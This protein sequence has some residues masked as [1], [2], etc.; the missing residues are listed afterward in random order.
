MENCLTYALRIARY[1]R[2]GDHLVIRKSHWGFF[3]HFA[4]L[5]ELANGDMVRKEY[6]PI[7]PVKRWIPPLFFKG[8]EVTTYYQLVEVKNGS[9]DHQSESV[10]AGTPTGDSLP[11]CGAGDGASSAVRSGCGV[12][13]MARI[14]QRPSAFVLSKCL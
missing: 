6:V 8:R 13:Y 12:V 4:V 7:N 1:G 2:A 3:P 5:F 14:S 9:T 11:E 10:E